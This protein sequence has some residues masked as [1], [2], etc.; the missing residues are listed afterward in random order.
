MAEFME[1]FFRPSHHVAGRKKAH[2]AVGDRH[3]LREIPRP[4]KYDHGGSGDYHD[5]RPYSVLYLPK[6]DC[7]EPRKH[8]TQERVVDPRLLIYL[9]KRK[10]PSSQ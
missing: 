6:A 7:G 3:H 5:S 4:R 9:T 8:G 2:I 10:G 1:Q